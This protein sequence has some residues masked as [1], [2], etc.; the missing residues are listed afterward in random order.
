MDFSFDIR[1]YLKPYGKNTI[2]TD[3]LKAGF[4]DSF[5]D[6]SFRKRLYEGHVRYNADLKRVLNGRSN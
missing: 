6:D 2:N 3:T 1:G 5:D 4:V